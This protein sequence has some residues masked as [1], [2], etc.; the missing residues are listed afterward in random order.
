MLQLRASLALAQLWR[1]EGRTG[2]ARTVLGVAHARLTEGFAT[3]DLR[4][5]QHLLDDLARD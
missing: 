1:A 5:A 3:P 2:E 4:D